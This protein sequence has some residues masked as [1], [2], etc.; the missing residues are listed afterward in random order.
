MNL[1]IIPWLF[2]FILFTACTGR[3]DLLSTA[4]DQPGAAIVAAGSTQLPSTE[5]NPESTHEM[6]WSTE[7]HPLQIEEMR[8]R[9]YTSSPI[10]IEQTL[11]AGVNYNRYI[12]SYLSEGYTIYALMTVPFGTKPDSGWPVI[13]FNHGYINPPDYRTT[14]NYVT[15]MDLLARSGYIVFKSDF[16]GHGNSEGS[17]TGGGYGSP[18]YSVDVLNAIESLK[19]YPDADPN[20]F[21]MWG[22]SMGGQVTLR[23]MVV[24]KDIKA[25]VIW[26]GAIAPY[27]EIISQWNFN[28]NSDNSGFLQDIIPHRNPSDATVRGW[29]ESFGSWTDEFTGKYGTSEQNPDFWQTISP[30]TY[31]ADLSGPI[32]IHHGTD[33]WMVPISWS[34]SFIQEMVNAGQSYEFYT[35]EG[36]DHNI[37]SNYREAMLRTIAFF[38]QYVKKNNT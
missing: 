2:L 18:D 4:M 6:L 32:Q 21:G 10:V 24:S 5:G 37:S 25:G 14:E 3:I 26:A 20:R 38:D 31:L 22:H 13:I 15:Y 8:K 33:D 9:I 27:P 36:D 30:N 11:D 35:Y 28:S 19:N 1:K 7:A 12:V 34:Q 17:I 16:R 29:S 23:A